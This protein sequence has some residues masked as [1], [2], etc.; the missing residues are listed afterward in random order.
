[1]ASV[2]IHMNN[3]ERVKKQK[4]GKRKKRRCGIYISQRCVDMY[5]VAC[6]NTPPFEEHQLVSSIHRN[7][8]VSKRECVCDF[9]EEEKK[10]KVEEK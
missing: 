1:M 8:S 6:S 3:K 4:L 2:E 7:E 5:H 10:H 9:K